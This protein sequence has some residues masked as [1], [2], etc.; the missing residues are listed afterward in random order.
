MALTHPA[1]TYFVYKERTI[2]LSYLPSKLS[3][4]LY[5]TIRPDS[6][7]TTTPQKTVLQTL[8]SD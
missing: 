7:N 4:H 3:L 5:V 1:F 6:P 2:V 8:T